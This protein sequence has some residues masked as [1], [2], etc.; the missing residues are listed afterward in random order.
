[1][2][3]TTTVA[4]ACHYYVWITMIFFYRFLVLWFPV[5]FSR[6]WESSLIVPLDWLANKVKDNCLPYC[7]S[8]RSGRGNIFIDWLIHSFFHS[9]IQW[10][11][12]ASDMRDDAGIF[13]RVET[14]TYRMY[15]M[16]SIIIFS[17]SVE[18]EMQKLFNVKL[19]DSPEWKW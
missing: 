12:Y 2:L 18:L 4:T 11:L 5:S 9:F 19:C 6:I 15:I 16:H 13:I 8:D 1:M 10:H 17:I 14:C 7:L 3:L